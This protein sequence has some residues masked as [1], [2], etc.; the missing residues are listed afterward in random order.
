MAITKFINL[1]LPQMMTSLTCLPK[2]VRLVFPPG[3]KTFL[4]L[5]DVC[6]D[7][8]ITCMAHPL[9]A[10]VLMEPALTV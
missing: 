8:E 6:K 2:Q 4:P 10:V 5:P 1:L 9:T 7:P 3:R